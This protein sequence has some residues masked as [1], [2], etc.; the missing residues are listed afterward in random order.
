MSGEPEC[1]DTLRS[2]YPFI[3]QELSPADAAHVKA[4]LDE[5]VPCHESFEFEAE[6]K[7]V[8]AERCR[9]D[10]PVQLYERVRFTLRF[11]EASTATENV[12]SS[13]E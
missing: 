7:H 13:E 9:D 11:E 3:D 12:V 8:I 4:H 5:C 10:V 1:H 2:M 6:L